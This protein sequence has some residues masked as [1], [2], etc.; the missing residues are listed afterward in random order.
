M[1]PKPVALKHG[2]PLE[3]KNAAG[4]WL[5]LTN[6]VWFHHLTE[7]LS[8]RVVGRKAVRFDLKPTYKNGVI[9]R[10][11][12]RASWVRPEVV[13][14]PLEAV[15]LM[16]AVGV[17]LNKGHLDAYRLDSQGNPV[18][19]PH[20]IEFKQGGTSKQRDGQLRQAITELLA[21]VKVTGALVVVCEQLGFLDPNLRETFGNNKKFRATISGF[22][23]ANFRNRLV[24]M[25][26]NQGI[27]VVG[28]DPHHTSKVGGKSWKRVI[29]DTTPTTPNTPPG[30]K[31]THAA[32]PVLLGPARSKKTASKATL[33]RRRRR[34]RAAFKSSQVVSPLGL[35]TGHSGAAV[36]IGRRGIGLGISCRGSSSQQKHGRNTPAVGLLPEEPTTTLKTAEFNETK[37]VK[38]DDR[39]NK[40]S[41]SGPGRVPGRVEQDPKGHLRAHRASPT[42]NNP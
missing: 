42:P 26:H 38:E 20:L 1:V 23:T 22:P 21:F 29:K 41:S 19:A 24:N 39:S 31:P 28:V 8:D 40:K 5:R 25:A 13:V 17:D 18:G 33:A 10:L 34:K 35:V 11:N 16:P 27:L 37:Q 3:A 30:T 36:A 2:I 7:E 15:Q 4:G 6:P 14:P 32:P 12:A 9:T